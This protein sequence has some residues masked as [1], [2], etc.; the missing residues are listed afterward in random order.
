MQQPK[1]HMHIMYDPVN[2]GRRVERV[3]VTHGDGEAEDFF[4]KVQRVYLDDV[5]GDML[6]DIGDQRMVLISKAEAATDQFC[7]VGSPDGKLYACRPVRQGRALHA[8]EED[9]QDARHSLLGQVMRRVNNLEQQMGE[10]VDPADNCVEG[11]L[12]ALESKIGGDF[13]S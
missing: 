13:R 3:R 8:I 6:W 7:W 5:E 11:R 9:K 2:G 1:A 12:R 4:P 10:R